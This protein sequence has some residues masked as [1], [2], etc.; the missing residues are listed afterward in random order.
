MQ[1]TGF[2]KSLVLVLMLARIKRAK[3]EKKRYCA[4]STITLDKMLYLSRQ[5][6]LFKT[7]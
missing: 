4:T 1:C 2:K 5:I 3:L 7:V 6:I